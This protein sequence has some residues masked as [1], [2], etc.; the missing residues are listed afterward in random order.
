MPQINN[1]DILERLL[2]EVKIIHLQQIA[3]SSEIQKVKEQVMFTNGKIAEAKVEIAQ[4]EK[5]MHK[6]DR[7]V[8]KESRNWILVALLFGS[9]LWVKESRDVIISIV[10]AFFL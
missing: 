3:D 4:L 2:D 9:F 6:E 8:S 7:R 1:K 5:T 10:R